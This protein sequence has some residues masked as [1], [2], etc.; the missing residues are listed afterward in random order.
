MVFIFLDFSWSCWSFGLLS[1]RGKGMYPRDVSCSVFCGGSLWGA[2]LALLG[3]S[4]VI[5]QV[6]AGGTCMP[7]P[8]R[9]RGGGA[10]EPGC[11]PCVRSLSDLGGIS[12]RKVCRAWNTHSY[13]QEALG[14]WWRMLP[15]STVHRGGS[16]FLCELGVS[17]PLES[18]CQ[19]VLRFKE[20]PLR[21]NL[22]WA[23]NP[24]IL[25]VST[26]RMS[27]QWR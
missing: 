22:V 7:V 27:V 14:E 8:A 13:R 26:R 16:H 24:V 6:R 23:L 21:R 1:S 3:P 25:G 11:S 17:G 10:P 9:V 20:D 4:G 15:L 12:F 19:R 18:L 2:G 5:C